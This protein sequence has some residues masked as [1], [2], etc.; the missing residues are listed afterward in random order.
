LD[1]E[2]TQLK[3]TRIMNVSLA[4]LSVGHWRALSST[5]MAEINQMIA[6]SSKTEEASTDLQKKKH[7]RPRNKRNRRR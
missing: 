6:S 7:F 1:Y 3:R 2:V 4:K 5:E